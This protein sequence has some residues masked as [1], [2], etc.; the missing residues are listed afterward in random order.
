VPSRF[1]DQAGLDA[2]NS[3]HQVAG[4]DDTV[5]DN[6]L[7][8]AAGRGEGMGDHGYIVSCFDPIDQPERDDIEAELGVNDRPHGI[9]EPLDSRIRFVHLAFRV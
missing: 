2:G 8:G 9:P 1:P 7:H 5:G 4:A 3:G 6:P